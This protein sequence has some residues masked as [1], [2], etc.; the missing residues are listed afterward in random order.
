MTVAKL[1]IL[2]LVTDAFGGSGGI[3]QYNRDLLTAW[4][5]LGRVVVL[6]RGGASGV[7]APP[8]I[9]QV[10]PSAGRFVYVLRTLAQTIVDRPD[11]VFCGHLYMA[12]LAWLAARLA[13]ARLVVQVHGIDAWARPRR[14]QRW[15]VE[16]ADLILSVSRYTR[17][18][19]LAWSRIAPEKVVVLPNTVDDC[20]SPGDCAGA[21]VR[22][23][24]EGKMV[25]VSVG[26]LDA[27]ERYKG[28]DRVIDVLAD[29]HRQYPSLVY[30]IAGEGDDLPRLEALAREAGVADIVR[31][32]GR[33]PAEEL[34]DL[35]RAADLFAL[36]STGEG[37]GIVFLEAMA[38]GTPA[39]GLSD[40][41]SVDAL[42][43]GR[44]GVAVPADQLAAALAD[45]CKALAAAPPSD[46]AGAARRETLSQSVRRL[47]GQDIFRHRAQAILES[48]F[49]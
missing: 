47:F 15:A 45:G 42:A 13:K 7:E 37:F 38:C 5:R 16:R 41:G 24:F 44:L 1:K 10:T 29:L 19:L 46:G 48:A 4:S 40:A 2:A 49:S 20:F 6:P 25:V 34:P 11:I 17:S 14:W 43:E 9:E 35:Y 31:F 32:L 27:R 8:G 22:F 39:V 28:Q 18:R 26:R 33:V 36:P 3:A 30:A 12:P 23:G 21:R